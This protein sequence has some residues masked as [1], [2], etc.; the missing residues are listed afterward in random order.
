MTY[1]RYPERPQI[2]YKD[3]EVDIA[4]NGVKLR[5]SRTDSASLYKIDLLTLEERLSGAVEEEKVQLGKKEQKALDKLPVANPDAREYLIGIVRNRA[6]WLTDQDGK[7]IED[8]ITRAVVNKGK[9]EQ[10]PPSYSDSRTP[11]HAYIEAQRRRFRDGWIMIFRDNITDQATIDWLL[12][13]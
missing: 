12:G 11:N 5:F 13:N 9:Q 6:H 8:L 1:R 3:K 10:G 7:E 4:Y 2:W